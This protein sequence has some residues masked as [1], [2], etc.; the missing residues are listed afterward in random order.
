MGTGIEQP[1]VCRKRVYGFVG[2][3]SV[4]SL[5]EISLS[6]V[7]GVVWNRRKDTVLGANSTQAG[8]GGVAMTRAQELAAAFVEAI[9]AVI[10]TVEALTEEQWRLKTS[11]E[12]WPAGVVA[13]HIAAR[14]GILGLE[15]I[16]SGNPSLLHMDLSNIDAWNAREAREFAGCAKEETL[17]LLRHISSRVEQLVAGLT[18]DQLKA[19]G[20]VLA[21][22]PVTTDQWIVVMML[23]HVRSHHES[24]IQTVS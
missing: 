11:A 3:Y 21:R 10:K 20:E 22:G 23:T 18:D 7:P 16:V 19:R 13:H 2:S 5:K 15:G 4:G 8:P 6:A 9:E 14:S 1:G 24:I 17:D 12:G